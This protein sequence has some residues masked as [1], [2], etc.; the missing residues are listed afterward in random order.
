M[1]RVL[2]DLWGIVLHET[3]IVLLLA[4]LRASHGGGR[5]LHPLLMFRGM[6]VADHTANFASEWLPHTFSLATQANAM[7]AI[8]AGWMGGF[9]RYYADSLVAPFDLAIVFLIAS[10]IIISLKWRENR[11]EAVD[12]LPLSAYD[13]DQDELHV[14]REKGRMSV[15][16]DAIRRDRKV[17]L[18]GLTQSLFEG[19]MYIFV[20]M[21]TPKLEADFDDLP[22]GQVFGCF[23]CCM[24]LGSVAAKML[25]LPPEAYLSILFLASSACLTLPALGIG[26]GYVHVGCFFLFEICVGAYWP[27][28]S[29]VKSKYVPEEARAT[30]YNL[31]RVPLNLIVVLVLVNLG[32][33]PDD[34]VLL[35]CGSMLAAASLLARRLEVTLEAE[36]GGGNLGLSAL[37]VLQGYLAHKKPPP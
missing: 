37:R 23:M 34:H 5:N 24:M 17:V 29:V 32:K 9:V 4:P 33:I 36:R 14:R 2:P 27:S 11:G 6:A 22:H 28:M 31:F 30:L 13:R 26:N 12:M 8:L 1:P 15:A 25:A 18:I 3:F 21:W 7:G 19:S 20:F 35:L 16:M 10:G